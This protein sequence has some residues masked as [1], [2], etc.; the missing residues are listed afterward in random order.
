MP[1]SAP[2][3]RMVDVARHAGVSTMSVSYTYNQ[4]DRV[5]SATRAKVLA[6]AE[7][8]GY[9]GPHRG[10]QSLRRGLSNNL[11]VV[12]G[13]RLSYVFDDPGGRRFLAGIADACLATNSGLVLLPNSGIR[14]DTDRIRGAQVDGY[15]LWTTVSD[16][17]VIDVVLDTGKPACIQGGPHREGLGFVGIDDAAAAQAVAADALR[18]ASRPA[19]LAFPATRDRGS[20]VIRGFHA[21][22]ATFPVTAAR[23]AGYRAAVE[24]HGL[25][26]DDV[27]VAL[28]SSNIRSEGARLGRVLI[29]ETGADAVLAMSDELA[30]GFLDAA[31]ESDTPIP[32]QVSVCGW[33]D[34]P[35]AASAG[36]TTVAQSLFEQGRAA[37]R[38]VLETASTGTVDIGAAS[39]GPEDIRTAGTVAAGAPTGNE[40]TVVH[41]TSTR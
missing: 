4:P 14:A 9:D 7:H 8:L 23:L 1:S 20:A 28:A 35:D 5:S 31:H 22:Q 33:D 24:A 17:P 37:A 27:P 36:L 39:T 40:W 6:A 29:E 32:Q 19:V 41:R 18:S 25:R 13:E 12:L 2:R 26:W 10:A 30:L 16:D 15:V 34:S 11:G 21:R 38:H 3:A